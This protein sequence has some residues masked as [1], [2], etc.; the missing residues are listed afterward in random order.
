[1][2]C[3]CGDV[4]IRFA[5]QKPVHSW[6]CCCVDC[7]AKNIHALKRTGEAMP[8]HISE[9]HGEGKPLALYYYPNRI[10]IVNG[11]EKIAFTKIRER[12]SSTN[13]IADCC[14]ALMCVDNPG[15]AGN[16][17]RHDANCTCVCVQ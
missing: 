15:Y 17:Y 13:M 9:I 10:T 14:G 1:M 7:Y 3:M 2:K 4:V 5:T 8:Q 6:E 16:H 11:R 12:A